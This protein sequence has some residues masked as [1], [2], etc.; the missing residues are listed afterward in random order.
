MAVYSRD[1]SDRENDERRRRGAGS[2]WY[3]GNSGG[4]GS[5]RP[6]E[7]MEMS[8][9]DEEDYE[10]YVRSREKR[11]GSRSS[12]VERARAAN[13]ARR[14]ADNSSSGSR[15][16]ESQY[17]SSSPDSRY[18]GP[19]SG[20]RTT[21]YRT[22]YSSSSGGPSS[23]SR[24]GDNR[25]DRSDGRGR[26][27]QEPV[28]DQG[29]E[30]GR[31]D[32]GG[33][34]QNDQGRQKKRK[35]PG[36][37]LRILFVLLLLVCIVGGFFF[38]KMRKVLNLQRV[39][40][41]DLE[42]T[43]KLGISPQVKNNEKMKGYKNIALFGVDSRSGDLLEGD[44]RSDSMMVCS[45]HEE[46]GEIRLVSVYRDT[47]LEV[48]DGYYTKANSAYAL[49][50]PAQAINML[51]QNFD[52]N[53]VDFVTVGFEGLAHTIDALG[54]IEIQID[55]EEREYL[56]QYVHDMHLEL[57]TEDTPVEESGTVL[58]NGIQA[59]AYSRIRYTAG[60]DFKR[61][62]R[63]RTVLQKTLDKARESGPTALVAVANNVVGDMA[64]SLSTAELLNL[65]MKASNL[66]LAGTGGLPQEEYR[67]FGS[68][69][70]D[71]EFILPLDLEENICWLHSFLFGEENYIISEEAAERNEY[72]RNNFQPYY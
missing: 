62:E 64:T 44:N 27:R 32:Q 39:N 58:M 13:S 28:M 21:A 36:I 14:M 68:T 54:G 30:N 10:E 23:G 20:S 69:Y 42:E 38:F 35:G 16:Q 53:I 31:N 50:G 25:T 45:I 43:L 63:Q 17:G 9:E 67:G 19:S 65:I 29:P 4:A 1:N 7:P 61:A 59:T 8:L 3:T 37:F 70:E 34:G 60:D 6:Q 48:G 12:A 33:N 18:G 2:P 26:S 66:E 41:V 46:T 22:S 49:G 55:E 57:G 51:N 15:T 47:I 40:S 5:R 71:G 72:I 52:L 56:N 11:Y 24:S